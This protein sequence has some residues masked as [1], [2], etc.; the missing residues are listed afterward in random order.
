MLVRILF[1]FVRGLDCALKL[2][3]MGCEELLDDYTGLASTHGKVFTVLVAASASSY[4]E[5]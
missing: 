1:R 2:L 4:T 3:S 5:M